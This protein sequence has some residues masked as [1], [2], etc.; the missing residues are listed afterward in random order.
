MADGRGDRATNAPA[1]ATHLRQFRDVLDGWLADLERSGGPDESAL[2]R[3]L[4][5]AREQL[6]EPA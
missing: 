5:A 1:I 6:G 3:R 4:A 2:A